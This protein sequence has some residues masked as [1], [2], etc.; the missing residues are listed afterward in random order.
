MHCL[1]PSCGSN[2]VIYVRATAGLVCVEC[3]KAA[4]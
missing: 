3:K 4:A 1:C 2:A